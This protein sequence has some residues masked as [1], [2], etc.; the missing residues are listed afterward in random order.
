MLNVFDHMPAGALECEASRLHEVLPGPSLIHL[1][2]R[3]AEPLFVSVLLHGNEDT[4]WEAVREV[5]AGLGGRALPRALSLFVGNV[6]AARYGLRQL[7]GQADFNRVWKGEGTAEHA[8]MRQVVDAMRER[9]PFAS[10]DIHNNTGFNPHY[11]CVNRLD[12][13]FFHL[14]ALFSRTVV[15]FIRPEG[16]QS[17]AFADLC[18]AVTVECGQPGQRHGVEHA[19]EFVEATLR[20]NELPDHPIAPHDID[21]FHTVAVVKVEEDIRLALGSE[22]GEPDGAARGVG[23]RLPADIDHLNFQELPPGT[24]FGWVDGGDGLPIY[25]HNELGGEVADRYFQVDEGVLRTTRPLMPSMLTRNLDI[26]RSDCLCYL[27]E[28]L[29]TSQ[30]QGSTPG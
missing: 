5:L 4:G 15:Y 8:L 1:P 6:A 14:A 3:N 28:R 29:D 23:L 25:A 12:Q 19:A 18:P 17:A 7:E 21:L 20:L 11:G 22:G 2:G 9:G 13:R 30:P 26:V 10:I 16:V 24:A 27:M